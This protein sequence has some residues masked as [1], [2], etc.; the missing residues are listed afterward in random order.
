[1]PSDKSELSERIK[2]LQEKIR[3][4]LPEFQDRDSSDEEIARYLHRF[5]AI[6]QRLERMKSSS[7][8]NTAQYE[9]IN[10]I[11][12][13]LEN[14]VEQWVQMRKKEKADSVDTYHSSFHI[15]GNNELLDTFKTYMP[16][17]LARVRALANDLL[18]ASGI[19][20]VKFHDYRDAYKKTM[21]LL[22][23]GKGGATKNSESND[24]Q[25]NNVP[26]A[27]KSTPNNN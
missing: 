14:A 2:A 4:A 16:T 27:N 1:M 10:E 15:Q 24:S 26:G 20:S 7:A 11:F 19:T 21:D 23:A 17:F 12:Q 13:K 5:E 8:K 3:G 9:D 6:N 22:P 18:A 25:L